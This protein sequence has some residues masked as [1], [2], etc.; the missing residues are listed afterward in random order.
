[1]TNYRQVAQVHPA[2]EPHWVGDGFY[3]NQMFSHMADDKRTDPFLMLDYAAPHIYQ[4]NSFAPRGVG[5]HPHK[6]FETV[7]I[8]YSGEVSHRDSSGGGGTIYPGDTQW[9]TAGNGVIHQEFHS[10]NF[11]KTGGLFEMVQL[12]V[13]L[14]A[15]D[16][17]TTPKYQHLQGSKMAVVDLKDQEGNSAGSVK[18]IAGDFIDAK[19]HL[20]KAKGIAS[21]FTPINLWDVTVKANKQVTL[22][23]PQNHNLL[24]L[25]RQGSAIINNDNANKVGSRQLVTFEVEAGTSGLDFITIQGLDEGVQ[26]LL[27]SGEP[28]N[29]PVVGYGPF[30]MNTEQEIRQAFSDF[31]AGKFGKISN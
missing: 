13:N 18:L 27:M 19:D 10:E 5:Q 15:K 29:E 6:G 17:G 4:P 8:A 11:S 20:S 31:R 24:L 30:V 12:W 23:V 28:L 3:V 16:K 14:P 1:M 2:P 26:V 21:T 25:V 22:A 7:T 9:M